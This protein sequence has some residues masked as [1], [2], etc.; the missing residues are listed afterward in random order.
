MITTHCYNHEVNEMRKVLMRVVSIALLSAMVLSMLSACGSKAAE[1]STDELVNAAVQAALEAVATTPAV[2]IEADGKQIT[3]EDASGQTVR[4]LLTQADIVLNEGDILSL[5][6]DQLLT[7]HMMLRVIRKSA[8]TISIEE[9]GAKYVITLYDGTVADALAAAGVELA[10]YHTL[11]HE[12]AAALEDGM[13][14]VI[15]GEEEVEETEPTEPKKSSS[16]GSSSGSS[17]SGSSSS[18]N[19]KTV[20]SVQYYDDCDGSGHG[21]KV[22]TYSDGTQKEVPY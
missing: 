10:E 17:S 2:T 11:S 6:P 22:I 18:S 19:Q 7:D 14:I 1:P 16:G 8:V 9:T 12:Q 15:S 21:V 3:I 13:E 5:S 4:Q 20:V